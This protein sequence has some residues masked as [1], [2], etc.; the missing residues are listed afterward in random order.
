MIMF[1]DSVV[2][3]QLEVH[4]TGSFGFYRE[5]RKADYL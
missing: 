4:A 1:N 3:V 2:M 5:F